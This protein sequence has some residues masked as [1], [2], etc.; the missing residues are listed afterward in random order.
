MLKNTIKNSKIQN[1][2][3]DFVNREREICLGKD[4]DF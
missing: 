3:T 1:R 2:M 4:S